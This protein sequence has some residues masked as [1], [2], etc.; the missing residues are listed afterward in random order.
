MNP[1]LLHDSLSVGADGAPLERQWQM[2]FYRAATVALSDNNSIS[3]DVG[4][5][6]GSDGFIDFYINGNLQ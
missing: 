5:V 6:F 3:P 2:E 1:K 4:R